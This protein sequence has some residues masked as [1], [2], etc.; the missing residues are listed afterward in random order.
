MQEKKIAT[1][2]EF[3]CLALYAFGG[4]GLEL[5]LASGIEPLLYGGP[6]KQWNTW[7]NILHWILT[8]AVWTVVAIWIYHQAKKDYGFDLFEKAGTMKPW[9][10]GAVIATMVF[11]LAMSYWDW[12]GSKVIHE[13]KA[14]GPLKFVFQYV[15]YLFETMLFLL[16]IVFGQKALERWF[17]RENVPYGGIVVALTWGIVHIATKGSVSIGLLSAVSGFLF[18]VVYLLVNRDIKKAY[19]LLAFMFVL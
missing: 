13:W 16:I 11:T 5:V 6:M 15:Y 3:F 18:G 14:N 1:G 10:W 8:C 9:Q 19:V 4:L 12:N 17:K 2:W 7:Q